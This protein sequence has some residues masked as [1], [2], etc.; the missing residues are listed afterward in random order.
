MVQIKRVLICEPQ[1]PENIFLNCSMHIKLLIF[2]KFDLRA[3]L[4]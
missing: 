1:L 4:P 3:K 2:V